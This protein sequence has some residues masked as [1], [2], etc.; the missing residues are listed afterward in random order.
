MGAAC[1]RL[2]WH[3]KRM[4][5][6]FLCLV[7][8]L[9]LVGC[10]ALPQPFKTTLE[11]KKRPLLDLKDAGMMVVE[12]V[13][14]PAK[15]MAKLLAQS[16]ADGLVK[17]EVVAT[18]REVS[19]PRFRLSGESSV[20]QANSPDAPAVTLYWLL[21]EQDGT[22]IGRLTQ[23]LTV[24]S[25]QWQ[26][27]DPAMIEKVGEEAAEIVAAFIQD[28]SERRAV[29]ADVRPSFFV[30]TPTGAPGS[31][32]RSLESSLKGMLEL[33]GARLVQ[34]REFAAFIVKCEVDASEEKDQK[35]NL[36]V[37]WILE[38]QSGEEL[39]RIRQA[40]WVEAGSLNGYWGRTAS[41]IA[42]AAVTSI[43]D[44]AANHQKVAPGK[45][46]LRRGESEA[47]PELGRRAQPPS[48]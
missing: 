43:A 31:G 1:R 22:E 7:V 14:G 23:G 35:Q 34:K 39:G 38:A 47:L 19:K 36:K 24:S 44:V 25:W 9:G 15:P 26:Y 29:A 10:G 11:E 8:L 37:V 28:E 20:R 12:P 48:L 2:F 13:F 17:R 27:G 4:K 21:S 6:A 46:A 32:N 30:E 41:I 42:R 18:T 33:A 45:Q 5:R 16:L 40:N 3:V